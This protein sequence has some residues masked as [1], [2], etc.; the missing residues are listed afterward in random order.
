MNRWLGS[1][2]DSKKQAGERSQRAA[3]RTIS[4]LPTVTSDSDEFE[5]CNTSFRLP[6]LDGQEDEDEDESAIMVD[7]A[8]AA[9]ELARQRALPFA[10]SDYDNDPDFWKKELK[11]K[12]D[13]NDVKYWFNYT[14]AELTTSE[15]I[16]NGTRKM[17]F[18]L[19]SRQMS[20]R[21]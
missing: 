18:Y 1:S 8:A 4:S 10:D 9:A 20:L 7:A 19:C 15:L 11:M 17:R 21:S 6:N 14:E 13:K 3:R 12:F 16:D 2:A 5:D